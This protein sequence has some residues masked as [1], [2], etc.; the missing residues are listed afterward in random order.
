MPQTVEPS[1]EPRMSFEVEKVDGQWVALRVTNR[2]TDEVFT[3]PEAEA[4]WADKRARDE[5]ARVAVEAVRAVMSGFGEIRLDVGGVVVL[6]F[7]ADQAEELGD[8]VAGAL[9][10]AAP[11]A[12]AEGR[13][14]VVWA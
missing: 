6:G 13:V 4:L 14:A 3:G 8:A 2:D 1:A 10:E 9:I 12:V 5:V 7:P 11:A